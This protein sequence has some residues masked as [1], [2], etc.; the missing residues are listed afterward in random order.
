MND[1][2]TPPAGGAP[3]ARMYSYEDDELGDWADGLI[4][5]LI[6]LRDKTNP[7]KGSSAASGKDLA[8]FEA[9]QCAGDLVKALA[10]WAIDHQIGLASHGLQF[11]P[12]ADPA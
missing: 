11:V 10:G 2:Q 8:A 5:R 12:L 6:E 9:L 4:K 7:D 3:L 1:N